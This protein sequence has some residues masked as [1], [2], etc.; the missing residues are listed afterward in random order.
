[1]LSLVGKMADHVRLAHA[2]IKVVLV[3]AGTE[4]KLL[5][6]EYF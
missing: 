3:F 6:A 4:C 2:Q 5:P 1:M